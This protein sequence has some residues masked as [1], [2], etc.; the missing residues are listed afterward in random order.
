MVQPLGLPGCGNFRRPPRSKERHHFLAMEVSN[1]DDKIDHGAPGVD[2]VSGIGRGG[3]ERRS[4]GRT[5]PARV[6]VMLTW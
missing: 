1:G 2:A 3:D 5:P 6:F 4:A